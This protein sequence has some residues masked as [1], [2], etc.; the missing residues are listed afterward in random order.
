MG[1][2]QSVQEVGHSY[3]LQEALTRFSECLA[4][5]PAFYKRSSTA[6]QELFQLLQQSRGD[7]VSVMIGGS[8]GR[9]TA[10]IT[11][12]FDGTENKTLPEIDAVVFIKDQEAP[13]RGRL[14][15][16]DEIFRSEKT[17]KTSTIENKSID[18]SHIRIE[19]KGFTINVYPAT[20]QLATNSNSTKA[21]DLLLLTKISEAVP[22][23]SP[24]LASL[25]YKSSLEQS[26][27]RFFEAQSPFTKSVIRLAKFWVDQI[28]FQGRNVYSK[29]YLVEC[30]A[31]HATMNASDEEDIAKGFET[32]LGLMTNFSNIQ[33][34]IGKVELP[35]YLNQVKTILLDPVNPYNNLAEQVP[36]VIERFEQAASSTLEKIRN[37]KDYTIGV[38]ELRSMVD[39]AKMISPV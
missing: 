32:F 12:P 17:L 33:A 16:F 28:N 13:F 11:N 4:P 37:F 34:N 18:A 31:C 7:V 14:A 8:V 1:S 15:E 30:L 3:G 29:A 20:Y 35:N 21:N 24:R 2:G 27:V 6:V 9:R 23:S 39:V 36:F 25:M 10:M 5:P 26:S 19:Y 22:S 38:E